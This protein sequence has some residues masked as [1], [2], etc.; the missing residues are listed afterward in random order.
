M[1]PIAL[2]L[3]QQGYRVSGSDR[4]LSPLALVVR[5]AGA[6]VYLGHQPANVAGAGLVVRSSAIPAD[7]VEVQAAQAAGIPVLKRADFLPEL[8]GDRKVIAIAGTHGKTTTTGTVAWALVSLGLDPSFLVGSNI[9]NLGTNAHAGRGDYFVIEADEYDHMFFGLEPSL[10]VVTNVEHDHP[11]F[12]PTPEAFYLAFQEFTHRL[13]PG[14]VLLACGDDPGA[15]RL[16]RE[17][18]PAS[19]RAFSYGIAD[20]KAGM[21]SDYQAINLKPNPKG[22][23]DFDALHRGLLLSRVS[24]QIPGQH[25]VRNTLAALAVLHQLGLDVPAG[26]QALQK[27]RGVGR[28]FE[29]RG[30]VSGITLIDDYAH[31]PTEIRAT[32]AAARSRYPNRRIWVVWQPHTYSR[33]LTFFEDFTHA[34]NDA[35]HVLVTEVFAAR[36]ANPKGF[37][38]R[39]V[40]DAIRHSD[41]QFVP[42]VFEAARSLAA[43]LNP[44]SVLIVLSAGDANQVIPELL[45]ILSERMNQANR[46]S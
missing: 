30:E 13:V 12:Y 1:A 14:G 18:R 35:D 20:E 15:A 28:R 43:R 16:L 21:S 24:L 32:L 6:T 31:H 29:V 4:Q 5:E 19:Q 8:I 41:V 33:A 17:S 10:A 2:I 42:T 23:Y 7:N 39:R 26:A 22:G 36:E 46:A 45:P 11:D 25:N 34:F 37:S 40:S 27:F 9:I 38:A 3:L 44:G